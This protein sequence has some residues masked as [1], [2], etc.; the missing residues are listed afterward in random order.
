MGETS[1][2]RRSS[3][4]LVRTGARNPEE[5]E[6]L[7]E[8]AFVIRDRAAISALFEPDALIADG[9]AS[10]RGDS[11]GR[12]VARRWALDFTYLAS[13]RRVLQVR[14]TAL[15]VADGAISVVH[16]ACDARWRY[17]IAL[18]HDSLGG[19]SS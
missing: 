11:V 6:T 10:A 16:R 12:F 14:D 2:A 19:T 7:L 5:L 17:A 18:H 4:H 1:E 9:S 15:I 13:P 8:D 3:I